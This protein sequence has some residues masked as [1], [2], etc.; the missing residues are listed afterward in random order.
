MKILRLPRP[1]VFALRSICRRKIRF[2]MPDLS[3]NR[4]LIQGLEN[5]SADPVFAAAVIFEF[6]RTAQAKGPSDPAI[7]MALWQ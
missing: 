1:E 3:K 4:Q 6:L 5:T 2:T 7:G